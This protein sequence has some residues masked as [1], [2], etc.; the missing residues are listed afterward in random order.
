MVNVVIRVNSATMESAVIL[1]KYTATECAAVERVI[2]AFAVLIIKRIA[3][4]DAVVDLKHATMVRAA[5]LT[6]RI[7]IIAVPMGILQQ[8]L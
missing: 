2:R 1:I 8:L 3:M 6:K 5:A 7:A 4:E